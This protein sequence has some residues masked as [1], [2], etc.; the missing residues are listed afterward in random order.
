MSLFLIQ[1][2]LSNFQCEL[3]NYRTEAAA[4]GL[5]VTPCD[6]FGFGYNLDSD[7]LSLISS[8]TLGNYYFIPDPGMLA[9]LFCNAIGTTLAAGLGGATIAV[10]VGSSV[11]GIS[12]PTGALRSGH[13]MHFRISLPAAA[14]ATAVTVSLLPDTQ[15]AVPL[16]VPITLA[17]RADA[18]YPYHSYRHDACA[19]LRK[20]AKEMARNRSSNAIDI[21][22]AVLDKYADEPYERW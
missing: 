19:A 18:A 4:A 22:N 5:E 10:A 3:D 15:G 11:T 21:L 1:N 17:S 12:V 6:T 9:D 2:A 13:A 20:V 14:A 7:T 16:P 8:T